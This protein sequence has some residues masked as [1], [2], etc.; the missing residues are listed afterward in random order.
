ME[1]EYNLQA[2]CYLAY[3]QNPFAVNADN[4]MAHLVTFIHAKSLCSNK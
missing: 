4:G 2:A 1:P 3:M